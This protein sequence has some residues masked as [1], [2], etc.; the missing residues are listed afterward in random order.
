[1][2]NI[3]KILPISEAFSDSWKKMVDNFWVL[4][5][6]VLLIILVFCV[7]KI[8]SHQLY[9]LEIYKTDELNVLRL[10]GVSLIR[11][12]AIFLVNLFFD[13]I[14]VAAAIR[15]F[16]QIHNGEDVGT[17]SIFKPIPHFYNFFIVYTALN[18]AILFGVFLFAV[19]SFYVALNYSFSV[20][21]S[22]DKKVGVNESFYLSRKICYGYR[23]EL[24]K[25]AI[26]IVLMNVLGAALFLVGL[27]ISIPM[28]FLAVIYMYKHL[29]HESEH[30]PESVILPPEIAPE[31][32][33]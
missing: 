29:L 14:I 30:G 3:I 17:M 15:F 13:A 7:V 32:N 9:N 23:L 25:F 6:T 31:S 21:L 27:V 33:V 28:S 11:D 4:V 5:N 10:F 16:L 18:F 1:M 22:I 2:P 26:V 8:G 24:L 12:A 20:Y 19:P